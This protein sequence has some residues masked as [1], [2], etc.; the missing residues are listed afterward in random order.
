MKAA[1][2]DLERSRAERIVHDSERVFHREQVI[3]SPVL[4]RNIMLLAP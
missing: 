2:H 1:R 4:W 3:Q